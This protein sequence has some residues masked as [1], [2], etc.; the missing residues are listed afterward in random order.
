MMQCSR[1]VL[2]IGAF[3]D[4]LAVQIPMVDRGRG[5]ARNILGV[6]VHRDAERDQHKIVVKAGV[7]KG[8][9]SRN[10]LESDAKKYLGFS[11]VQLSQ[12]NLPLLVNILPN[13][14]AVEQKRGRQMDVTLCYN[15][16]K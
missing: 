8:Q 15:V 11:C 16:H 14:T 10:I 5:D 1:V 3:G 2:Q 6:I 4:I 7:L 9:Y 13:A 12:H